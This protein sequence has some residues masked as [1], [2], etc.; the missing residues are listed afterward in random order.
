MAKYRKRPVVIDAFH[1]TGDPDQA[2]DVGWIFKAMEEGTVII[3]Y[4]WPN[5]I[6]NT[7]EGQMTAHAGD[8]IIRGVQGEIYPCRD[9]IF[10]ATYEPAWPEGEIISEKQ[11]HGFGTPAAWHCGCL[12]DAAFPFR[13]WGEAICIHCGYLRPHVGG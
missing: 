1:W 11:Q 4:P 6:I 5:M 2:E 13:S 3:E 10:K 9:D 8:W 12:S 7:L